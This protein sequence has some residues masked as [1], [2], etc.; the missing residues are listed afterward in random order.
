[1]QNN[2]AAGDGSDMPIGLGMLLME[3]AVAMHNFTV[4]SPEEK[5]KVLKYVESGVDSQDAKHRIWHTVKCLREGVP[6]FYQ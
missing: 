6:G 4:L 5:T 3:D 1:M 2:H